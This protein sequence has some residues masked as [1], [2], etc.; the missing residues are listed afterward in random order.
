MA[1]TTLQN[2]PLRD[3]GKSVSARI[4]AGL[5]AVGRFLSDLSNAR[6]CALEAERLMALSDA[7]LARRGLRR[8]EIVSHVFRNHMHE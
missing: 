6:R 2:A 1:T 4:G 7:Q 8:D 3:P 5:A